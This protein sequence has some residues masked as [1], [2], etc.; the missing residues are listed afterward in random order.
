MLG[1]QHTKHQAN[2]TIH[3]FDA[4]LITNTY[5]SIGWHFMLHE[6]QQ[7][8]QKRPKKQQATENSSNI[9]QLRN[10]G[11]CVCVYMW[12]KDFARVMLEWQIKLYTNIHY[13]HLLNNFMLD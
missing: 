2:I 3:N 5:Y 9:N 4:F 11:A 7:Q 12:S 13:L 1:K 8:Q 10:L 6:Q